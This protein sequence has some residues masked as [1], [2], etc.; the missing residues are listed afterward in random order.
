M[1]VEVPLD[2]QPEEAAAAPPLRTVVRDDSVG[3]LSSSKLL[4]T[5]ELPDNIP[6]LKNT[7]WFVQFYYVMIK[8]ALLLYRRPIL[9]TAFVLSSVLSVV[10]AGLV[11]ADSD[12][13][14]FVEFDECGTVPYPE[15]QKF[16]YTDQSNVQFSLNEPWRD[17]I[18][19]TLMVC[20]VQHLLCRNVS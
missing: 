19:V 4:N 13:A 18:A 14:I 15:V 1:E 6:A 16:N 3:L 8:N 7:S 2:S 17:G 10:I 11:A 9:M 5:D 12:N 20:T